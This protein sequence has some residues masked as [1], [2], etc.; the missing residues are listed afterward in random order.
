MKLS[1]TAVDRLQCVDTAHLLDACDA[2]LVRLSRVHQAA[3]QAP[4]TKLLAAAARAHDRYAEATLNLLAVLHVDGTCEEG[5][6][7]M[8]ARLDAMLDAARSIFD[9]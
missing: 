5:V 3:S 8:R 2:L 4:D 7:R 6:Q 1:E 9:H